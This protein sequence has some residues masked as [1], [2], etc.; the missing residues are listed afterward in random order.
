MPTFATPDPIAATIALAAGDVRI[1]ASDRD[2]TVVEV[3]PSD[4]SN[5][6]DVKAAEQTRVEY[7]HGR[8]LIKA[9]KQW[10]PRSFGR[11]GSIDVAIELP[12]DS[13]VEGEAAM[14]DFACD[15]RLG[16]C[17]LTTA[18][19]S[20][21]L[22]HAGPLHLTTSL[23]TITVN[24]AVGRTE[25]T[26]S[27]E[28]RIREIDGSA[29]VKNLNGTTWLGEV[30]GDVR[31]NAANGDITVDRAHATVGATTAHGD[32]RI[33][34]VVRGAVRL[35]TAAGELEV[36]IRQGTAAL[37][38][39]RS[40]FGSIRSSLTAADAP[41]PSDTTVDVHARTSYGDIVIRRA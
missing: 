5:E 28:L 15:G 8:L 41:A 27:G 4:P 39:V 11:G 22:D 20:I 40:R 10:S 29:V 33:G 24:R 17:R 3:S 36:G 7:A 35:V 12:A 2:D 1:S 19:G 16:A 26:G 9:P 14:A 37:L 32:V 23:G 21:R 31:C 6:S 18:T 25:V 30:T 13:Q 38:D 34:E